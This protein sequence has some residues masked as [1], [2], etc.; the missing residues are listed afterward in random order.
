MTAPRVLLLA[1][2]LAPYLALVLVD[3]WMH[4]KAR[5]VPKVEQIFH[6]A[7]ALLFGGFVAS[8]FL[9]SDWAIVLL[10]AYVFCAGVDE[11]G[12]HRQLSAPE[13]R[14]HFVSYAALALFI[15]AWRLV[16]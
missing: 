2:A 13:R 16:P 8:V 11:I 1:A 7:A 12:F 9:R 6:G 3:A 10:L 4:E 5:T 15:V 14:V